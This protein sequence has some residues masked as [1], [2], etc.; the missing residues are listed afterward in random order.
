MSWLPSPNGVLK[1]NFDASI[2]Q[3]KATA[4]YVIRDFSAYCLRVNGRQPP[5]SFVP[6]AELSVAWLAM[7]TSICK[8]QTN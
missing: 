7:K 3:D 8:F 5:F 4:G 6:Y 1:L 2:F